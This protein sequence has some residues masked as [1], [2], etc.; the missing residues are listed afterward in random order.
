MTRAL[1]IVVPDQLAAG[2]AR[3]HH[4]DGLIGF[5]RLGMAHG[6]DGVDAGLAELGDGAAE[7]DR[8][9]ADR[10]AAEIGVEID[11]GEDPPVARAQRRA[12]L[13]PV[14]AVA[15]LDRRARRF[16]QFMVLRAQHEAP[17]HFASSFSPSRISCGVSAPS[18]AARVAAAMAA[19]AC[20]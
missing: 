6:D 1:P 15:P 17:Y 14:V 7:R 20:G 5:G 2:A 10:H 19:A 9:G 4:R 13:L 3:R 8:F 16:D 12:D 18:P 11:A